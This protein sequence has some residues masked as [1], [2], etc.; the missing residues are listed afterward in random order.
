MF[1]LSSKRRREGVHHAGLRDER[2]QGFENGLASAVEMIQGV[3][4]L[5]VDIG[6]KLLVLVSGEEIGKSSFGGSG[7]PRKID[8]RLILNKNGRDDTFSRV[9]RAG[10]LCD[11]AKG[12]EKKHLSR[13]ETSNTKQLVKIFSDRNKSATW[14]GLVLVVVC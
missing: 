9:C 5:S 1:I 2:R 3:L 4:V 13:M 8:I 6:A 14:C 7:V 11:K 10:Y 12:K